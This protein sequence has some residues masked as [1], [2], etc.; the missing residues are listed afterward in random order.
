[1]GHRRHE[2]AV[3]AIGLAVQ[4]VEHICHCSRVRVLGSREKSREDALLIMGNVLQ[5]FSCFVVVR[6]SVRR[7][8]LFGAARTAD[9]GVGEG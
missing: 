7:S 9:G 4:L 3:I 6:L 8:C 5:R 1:M 2:L